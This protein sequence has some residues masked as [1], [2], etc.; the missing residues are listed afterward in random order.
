MGWDINRAGITYVGSPPLDTATSPAVHDTV[1]ISKSGYDIE[2]KVKFINGL[3]YT[4]ITLSI[5][6]IIE[7]H[8]LGKGSGQEVTFFHENIKSLRR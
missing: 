6:P 2:V 1:V 4:G 3:K 5:E 8:A 7:Q